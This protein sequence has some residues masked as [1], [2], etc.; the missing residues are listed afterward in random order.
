[1]VFIQNIECKI[2]NKHNCYF[3]FDNTRSTKEKI[4]CLS[5]SET[6]CVST[7]EMAWLKSQ[8]AFPSIGSVILIGF[9]M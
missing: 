1:M 5:A 9:A 2:I 7:F 3:D 4:R 8:E 6:L